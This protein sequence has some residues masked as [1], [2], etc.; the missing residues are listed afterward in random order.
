MNVGKA[1]N[2]FVTMLIFN[3]YGNLGVCAQIIIMAELDKYFRPT[4]LGLSETA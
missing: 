1:L 3:K 2:M 4:L